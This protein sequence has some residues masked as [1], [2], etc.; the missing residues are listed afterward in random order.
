M[1]SQVFGLVSGIDSSQLIEAT[2]NARKAPIRTAQRRQAAV[3]SQISQL[4]SLISKMDTLKTT[5]GDLEENKDVLA[6]T[7]ASSDEDVLTVTATGESSPGNYLLEVTSLATTEKNRSS[8][9]ADKFDEVKAGT[10]SF[11]VDGEDAV[12][13]VIEDGDDLNAVVDK[14]NACLLYTSPSPRDKRQSRMPSSA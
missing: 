13:V 7:G 4:S 5:L 9:Y 2:L 3:K 11:A 12:D 1:S 8:F 14:I 10:I 6:L